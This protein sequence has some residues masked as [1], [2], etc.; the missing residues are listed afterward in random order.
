[1]CSFHHKFLSN[2]RTEN[3]IVLTLSISWLFIFNV[4]SGED[5][6]YFFPNLWKSKIVVFPIFTDKFF[7]ENGPLILKS[8]RH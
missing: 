5:M 3:L 7:A 6:L 8:I 4:S 2:K 1:M